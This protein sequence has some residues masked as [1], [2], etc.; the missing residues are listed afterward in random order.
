MILQSLDAVCAPPRLPSMVKNNVSMLN[1]MSAKVSQLPR[2]LKNQPWVKR[3]GLYPWV[4]EKVE[5]W[6]VVD[7]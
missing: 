7:D 6:P 4:W 2:S 3:S 1:V 5:D